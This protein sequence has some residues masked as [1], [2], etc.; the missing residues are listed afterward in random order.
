MGKESRS[1]PWGFPTVE[2]LSYILPSSAAVNFEPKN[3]QLK[4][5]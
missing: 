4:T 5:Q 3:Q 2:S 1:T